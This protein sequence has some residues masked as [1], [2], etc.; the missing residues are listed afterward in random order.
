[1]DPH[2]PHPCARDVIF[3][4]SRKERVWDGRCYIGGA[5]SAKKFPVSTHDH[6]RCR[7][8]DVLVV[9]DVK[10]KKSILSASEAESLELALL[11]GLF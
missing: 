11:N 8:R 10:Y 2:R 4:A 5:E 3:Q 7:E 6:F 9:F 1:M